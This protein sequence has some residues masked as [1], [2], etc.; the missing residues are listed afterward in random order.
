[1]ADELINPAEY[2]VVVEAATVDDC[3]F[4]DLWNRSFEGSVARMNDALNRLV[5]LST[6]MAG[7]SLVL[8]KEDICYG[9]FRVVAAALFFMALAVSVVGAVPVAVRVEFDPRSV[10]TQLAR[11][12]AVKRR[13]V[14]GATACL[15]A[16]LLVVVI[17]VFV[18][19]AR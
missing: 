13:W 7:G 18:R 1:M 10:R 17:G 12:A 16:G 8:L 3:F 4:L 5:T 14:W 15:L 11:S 6:A 19:A 9:L 2:D